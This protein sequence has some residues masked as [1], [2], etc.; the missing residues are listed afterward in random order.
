MKKAFTAMFLLLIIV[1]SFWGYSYFHP[2]DYTWPP[3]NWKQ[4]DFGSFSPEV[5]YSYD[6]K[7][8]AVQTVDEYENINVSIYENDALVDSFS[9]ARAW[10]FWGVCWENDSYNIWIQSAD[11][12]T[13]CML[14]ADG[15]WAR[16]E[17]SGLQMPDGMIDR[18]RMRQGSFV[19]VNTLS[20][21]GRYLAERPIA[22]ECIVIRDAATDAIL[23]SYPLD[24]YEN[25]KGFCW[26]S[27]SNLW[28]RTGNETSA[29]RHS[30]GTWEYD[31][32]LPRPADIVLSYKWDGTPN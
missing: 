29:L 25:Y 2:M 31:A 1:I 8:R 7:Y 15:K 16:S 12:G 6:N 24:D 3:E 22:E 5:T 20:P 19:Y 23:F 26:D 21:D 32:A 9:A 17:D 13:Y 18:F 30:G 4:E 10:D 27:D 28:L 14:F 11:V